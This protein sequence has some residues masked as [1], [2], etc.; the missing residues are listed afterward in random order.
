MADRRVGDIAYVAAEGD[1]RVLV[2]PGIEIS[3]LMTSYMT[4]VQIYLR[5]FKVCGDKSMLTSYVVPAISTGVRLRRQV[6]GVLPE[7]L[8]IGRHANLPSPRIKFH[9]A[10]AAILYHV[11][12]TDQVSKQSACFQAGYRS[13]LQP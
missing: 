2:T 4:D 13:I 12:P 1:S 3:R 5:V 8:D 6:L 10:F 9:S 7:M 11:A